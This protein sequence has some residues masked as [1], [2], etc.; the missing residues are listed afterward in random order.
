MIFPLF[1]TLARYHLK[2]CVQAWDHQNKKYVELLEIQRTAIRINREVDHLF[3]KDRLR[4]L[5]LLNLKKSVWTDTLYR[6][7]LCI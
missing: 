1:S 3:Y 5:G 6:K 7:P 4:D 2:Y